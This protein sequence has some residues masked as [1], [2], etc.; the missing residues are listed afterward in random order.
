MSRFFSRFAIALG[1]VIGIAIP[2]YW[3]KIERITTK[4]NSINIFAW[5]DMLSTTTISEFEKKSGIKVHLNYYSS[6]EELIVKLKATKGR[7]YDLVIPS[8]YAVKVLA[9]LNLLQEIDKKKLSFYSDLNP[10]LLNHAFDPDNRYSIP[11]GWEIFG[12]GIDRDY[13][14]KHPQPM[15]WSSVFDQNLIDYKITM[16]NDPMEA[17]LFAA[18]YL[19]NN[20]PS[21]SPSDI[22][23]VSDL[24][25]I[26]RKWVMAYADFR[27][28]YFLA[29][30]NCPLVVSSSSYIS[31]SK[32]KF[33]F[34]D[35]VIPEEG[36]FITIENIA[37]P[38][39]SKKQDLVYELINFLY[40]KQAIEGRYKT[41]KF[42]PTTKDAPDYIDL[43]SESREIYDFA[44][45]NF[46]KLHFFRAI[47][48]QEDLR[49]LW[50]EVKSG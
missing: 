11:F 3:A 14:I 2:V 37:I 1:W 36:T 20:A 13:F 32:E 16:I 44:E 41:F 49:D 27:G 48:P 45:N 31:R 9:Q 39:S 50:I 26:Q 34:I 5:G 46:E 35:F 23:Q 40:T 10:F 28:D 47:L 38:A 29:T 21:L 43:D 25:K 22:S 42:L 6:N 33:P 12:L 18:F 17:T 30:K 24:L 15:S 19:F 8:D 7:G 4:E